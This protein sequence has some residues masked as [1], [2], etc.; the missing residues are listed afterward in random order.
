MRQRIERELNP[1]SGAEAGSS[2]RRTVAE[3]E[4]CANTLRRERKAREAAERAAKEAR[5]AAE[6]AKRRQAYLASLC[7]REE[8]LWRQVHNLAGLRSAPA[9]T[10]RRCCGCRSACTLQKRAYNLRGLDAPIC[11]RD[12]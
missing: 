8:E 1:A 10:A 3:L 7:G 6:A 5:Q 4:E 9:R 11:F 2:E 12:R